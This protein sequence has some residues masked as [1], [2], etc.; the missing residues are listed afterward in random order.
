[1][2]MTYI[3][4]A[5]VNC[6]DTLNIGAICGSGVSA[7]MAGLDGIAKAG[8]GMWLACDT[9]QKKWIKQPLNLVRNVD[10]NTGIVTGLMGGAGGF[11]NGDVLGRRL[12][13]EDLQ[14]IADANIA[15]LQK[16]FA[17][18]EDA[19]KSIGFDMDD[20]DA[21]W[22]DLKLPEVDMA[23]L[24]SLVEE[25]SHTEAGLFGGSCSS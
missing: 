22:R 24:A 18:P 8:A 5:V 11:S 4:L 6:A 23:K 12:A 9:A 25:P 16:R 3:Q 2:G 20:A 7:M 13:T 19:F 17:T 21:P 14:D 1:M 10:K 15:E